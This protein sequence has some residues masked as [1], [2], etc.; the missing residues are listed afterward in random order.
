[1]T[2]DNNLTISHEIRMDKTVTQSLLKFEGTFLGKVTP[3][4]QDHISNWDQG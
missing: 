3:P 1:M 4:S 2:S